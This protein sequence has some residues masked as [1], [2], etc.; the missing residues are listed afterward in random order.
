MA[1]IQFQMLK[2]VTI[3]LPFDLHYIDGSYGGSLLDVSE[4]FT[5]TFEGEVN[6]PT[7]NGTEYTHVIAANSANLVDNGAEITLPVLHVSVKTGAAFEAAGLEY[8]NY[9]LVVE[10]VLYNAQ[11]EIPSTR[12]SNYVIYTNAKVVPTFVG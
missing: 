10:T 6:A 2:T 3:A 1:T 5:I 8:S 4:Y 12:V 9:R 11:G 7:D